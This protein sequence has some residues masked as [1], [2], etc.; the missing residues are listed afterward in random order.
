MSEWLDQADLAA[1]TGMDDVVYEN[2]GKFIDHDASIIG[3]FDNPLYAPLLEQERFRAQ[4][5]ILTDRI[6][7]ERAKL[8]LEPYRPIAGTD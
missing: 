8:G 6:N 2:V 1:V 7:T 3:F 5:K 4:D